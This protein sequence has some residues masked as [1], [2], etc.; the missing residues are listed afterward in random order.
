[1]ICYRV[2]VVMCDGNLSPVNAIR[3]IREAGYNNHRLA[4]ILLRLPD[5]SIAP[6]ILSDHFIASKG[7]FI[8]KLEYQT[9]SI[10]IVCEIQNNFWFDHLY[11]T[12]DKL[13]VN[14]DCLSWDWRC[15]VSL[16]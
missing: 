10:K 9:S 8:K 6:K 4:E 7:I 13:A 5:R 11:N 12:L 16:S 3:Y 2:V 15:P 14:R 1:M